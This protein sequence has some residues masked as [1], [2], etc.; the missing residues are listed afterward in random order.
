MS[1][2]EGLLH[3][4]YKLY[5]TKQEE[6]ADPLVDRMSGLTAREKSLCF[7][8]TEN[9][10]DRGQGEDSPPKIKVICIFTVVI[11]LNLPTIV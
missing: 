2:L 9:L 10:P 3:P 8:D 6:V 5:G 1:L 11:V 4:M 7:M